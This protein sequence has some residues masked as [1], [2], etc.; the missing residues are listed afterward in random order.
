MTHCLAV[1]R[2]Y[3]GGGSHPPPLSSLCPLPPQPVSLLHKTVLRSFS[4]LFPDWGGGWG[5]QLL[6][7]TAFGKTRSLHPDSACWEAGSPWPLSAEATGP[8]NTLSPS[9]KSRES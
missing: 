2:T 3:W 6:L 1:L 4:P 7:S 9:K 8:V 5:Q